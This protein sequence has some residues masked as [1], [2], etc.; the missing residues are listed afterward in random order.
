MWLRSRVC[1]SLDSPCHVDGVCIAPSVHAAVLMLQGAAMQIAGHVPG[2]THTVLEAWL[3]G[4]SDSKHHK[5]LKELSVH[6]L[7]QIQHEVWLRPLAGSDE[8]RLFLAVTSRDMSRMK[9]CCAL[10]GDRC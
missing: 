10:N 2:G 4:G 3:H 5:A 6:N 8:P 7:R 9:L 1:G